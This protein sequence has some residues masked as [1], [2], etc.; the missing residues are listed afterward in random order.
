VPGGQRDLTKKRQER[1]SNQW[2]SDVEELT[3]LRVGPLGGAPDIAFIAHVARSAQSKIVGSV[4][5]SHRTVIAAKREKAEGLVRMGRADR[6][7]CAAST[8]ANLCGEQGKVDA[9]GIAYALAHQLAALRLD[10]VAA[11]AAQL[12]TCSRS[13]PNARPSSRCVRRVL[14]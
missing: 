5:E 3:A 9:S 12:T 2:V 1:I 14:T 6:L 10:L 13:P 11:L 4:D 7:E 8:F